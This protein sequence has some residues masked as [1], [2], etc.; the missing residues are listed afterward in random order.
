[1]AAKSTVSKLEKM[2][3]DEYEEPLSPNTLYR[4]Q[5][6]S[7]FDTYKSMQEQKE[8]IT[9]EEIREV[10][11]LSNLN[12]S[13]VDFT[14][15]YKMKIGMDRSATREEFISILKDILSPPSDADSN[16]KTASPRINSSLDF[17]E[18]CI[19]DVKREKHLTEHKRY[20]RDHPLLHQILF[21]FLNT[22]L[23]Y[24]PDDVFSFASEYFEKL[25]AV[26]RKI[27]SNKKVLI[28]SG[29]VVSSS[30]FAFKVQSTF[31]HDIERAVSYTTRKPRSDEVE[32]VH[33]FFVPSNETMKEMMKDHMFYEIVQ[34]G[35]DYYG[36]AKSEIDSILEKDKVCLVFA[37]LKGVQQ[38]QM[39][40]KEQ[41][42]NT[43]TVY[44][45]PVTTAKYSTSITKLSNEEMSF[46]YC[47]NR[48]AMIEE[49][50]KQDLYSFYDF[51]IAF[52][53]I[54]MPESEIPLEYEM[55]NNLYNFIYKFISNK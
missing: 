41:N 4:E 16:P 9:L 32:G 31:P 40:F 37:N 36:N 54:Y 39:I 33:H 53:D 55:P 34:I 5:L 25:S 43:A 6:G 46:D 26:S 23:I 30:N 8:T 50:I 48:V 51:V 19:M 1:M 13:I 20:I 2:S 28:V 12:I 38:L 35:N 22:T 42:I 52:D 15:A 24:Q 14:E 47:S 7:M 45:K 18:K 10:I 44:V 17:Q 27:K 3:S 11:Q 21:D 49:E 29:A